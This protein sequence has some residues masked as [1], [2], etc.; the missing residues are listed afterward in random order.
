ML[1]RYLQYEGTIQKSHKDRYILLDSTCSFYHVHT[2]KLLKSTENF[3]I[4]LK[5]TQIPAEVTAHH[6]L[7][8]YLSQILRKN[9]TSNDSQT[10][11]HTVRNSQS[12]LESDE[13]S[14]VDDQSS[15]YQARYSPSMFGYPVNPCQPLF[16]AV[17]A[18]GRAMTSIRR[19]VTIR[20]YTRF[21][22]LLPLYYLCKNVPV[23]YYYLYVY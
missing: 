14:P 15:G 3:R 19:D 9:P 16:C 23:Y 12:Q 22:S 8:L 10:Y 11:Q 20:L 2:Y 13:K 17:Q 5:H 1:N 4:P 6:T 18:R 7:R 21:Q